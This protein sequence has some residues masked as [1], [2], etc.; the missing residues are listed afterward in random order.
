MGVLN[1]VKP[2][3]SSGL[4]FNPPSLETVLSL[5]GVPFDGGTIR[6]VSPYGN[7]GTITEAVWGKT[8]SGVPYLTFDGTN[9]VVNCSNGASLSLTGAAS[10]ECWLYFSV[11]AADYVMGNYNA[12]G[13]LGQ[14]GLEKLSTHYLRFYQTGAGGST[15]VSGTTQACTIN[16]WN[17]IRWTRVSATGTIT[18]YVNDVADATTG[19]STAT[20]ICA[21]GDRGNTTI[22]MLG[23]YATNPWTGR[24]ALPRLYNTVVPSHFKE[25]RILFGV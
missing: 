21:D 4:L 22:G 15:L 6:D 16:K 11:A 3:P 2:Q 24:I 10:F 18:L 9:D 25:E 17:H 5:T 7:N 1:S 19:T 8:P 13:A 20:T 14:Y 23:S 12:A